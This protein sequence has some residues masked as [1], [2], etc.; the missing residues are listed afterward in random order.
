MVEA[1]APKNMPLPLPVYFKVAAQ[2]LVDACWLEIFFLQFLLNI[3]LNSKFFSFIENNVVRYYL[4]NCKPINK[5]KSRTWSRSGS[6]SASGSPYFLLEAEAEAEAVRVEAEAEAEAEALTN[7]PL[8]HHW[9][10]GWGAGYPQ[11]TP[12]TCSYICPLGEGE[13][14]LDCLTLPQKWQ[15]HKWPSSK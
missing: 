7:W 9:P 4:T 6:G 13:G 2:I 12:P 11:T 8:P 15:R 5:Y 3:H 10:C 14:V 1:E